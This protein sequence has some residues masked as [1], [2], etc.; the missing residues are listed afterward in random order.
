MNSSDAHI[1]P[2][3]NFSV[4]K[5]FDKE[6]GRIQSQLNEDKAFWIGKFGII[7]NIL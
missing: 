1:F 4:K 2:L 3:N 6:I 7:K 5:D